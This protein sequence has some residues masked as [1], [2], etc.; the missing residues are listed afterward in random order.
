MRHAKGF[1][2]RV[3]N[4]P[5][6]HATVFPSSSTGPSGPVV[7][8]LARIGA[9]QGVAVDSR[10]QFLYV[11]DNWPDSVVRITLQTGDKQVALFVKLISALFFKLELLFLKVLARFHQPRGIAVDSRDSFLYVANTNGAIVRTLNDFSTC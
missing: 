3:S 1:V 10:D 9:P 5:G 4:L 7:V 2:L 8:V 6:H 11:A